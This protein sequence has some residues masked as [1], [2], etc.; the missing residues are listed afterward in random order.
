MKDAGLHDVEVL[1]VEGIGWVAGDL[2]ERLDNPESL[3]E[4]LR[5]L[6]LLERE[7]PILG[8]SPHLL[9]IGRIP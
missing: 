6:D 2:S 1:A 8:A 9:G 5:L 7:E 3:A 4:L